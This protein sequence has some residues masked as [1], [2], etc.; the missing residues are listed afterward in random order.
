MPHN[1][2]AL[3]AR[4]TE[5]A[6]L[7]PHMY[8][9]RVAGLAVRRAAG[10]LLLLALAACEG[11][12]AR[13]ADASRPALTAERIDRMLEVS[14]QLRPE[15]AELASFLDE[16]DISIG[17]DFTQLRMVPAA[18]MV[19]ADGVAALAA[20]GEDPEAFV[21]DL[22]WLRLTA[23]AV[24]NARTV[25]EKMRQ[26]RSADRKMRVLAMLSSETRAHMGD[27][28]TLLRLHARIGRGEEAAVRS[29][30][31]DIYRVTF[32]HTYPR[33]GENDSLDRWRD[34]MVRTNGL[35]RK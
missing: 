15:H 25:D 1:Y 22:F 28:R 34:S 8:P 20:A 14:E 4:L 18:D 10:L 32:R 21:R 17:Y 12:P 35:L 13:T 6:R 23:S 16:G 3:V 19:G 2:D 26:I 9:A 29:R 7:H 33:R 31:A 5:Y 24:R 11:M 30:M 27:M